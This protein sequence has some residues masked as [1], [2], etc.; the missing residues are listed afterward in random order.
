MLAAVIIHIFNKLQC[1]EQAGGIR[2]LSGFQYV[3]PRS[4]NYDVPASNNSIS[5]SIT[6][7]YAEL[8]EQSIRLV[9]F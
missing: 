4:H 3:C 8:Q 9:L 6:M 1:L 2:W 7:N 5:R